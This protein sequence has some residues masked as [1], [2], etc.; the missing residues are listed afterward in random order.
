MVG[1]THFQVFRD[2]V[3]IGSIEE[4]G[5]CLD[6]TFLL[7]SSVDAK[8]YSSDINLIYSNVQ[9][10]CGT[11]CSYACALRGCVVVRSETGI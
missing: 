9:L 1:G 11:L 6:E 7:R 5:V 10:R 4:M 2:I 3:S 8:S